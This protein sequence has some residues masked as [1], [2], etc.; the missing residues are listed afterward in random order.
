M[1]E[2]RCWF[3]SR[4][5]EIVT[6]RRLTRSCFIFSYQPIFTAMPHPHRAIAA[7]AAR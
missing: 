5:R 4:F 2:T 7:V 6:H 3:Q 1:P